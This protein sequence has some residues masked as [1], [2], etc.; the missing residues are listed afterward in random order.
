MLCS[1]VD[2]NNRASGHVRGEER[3]YGL[4]AWGGHGVGDLGMVQ[5]RARR[6]R[7]VRQAHLAQGTVLLM[8]GVAAGFLATTQRI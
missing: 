4:L 1:W 5:E 8:V 7:L 6:L 3:L 2:I